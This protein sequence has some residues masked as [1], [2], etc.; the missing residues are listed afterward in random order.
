[1]DE[2]TDCLLLI[3]LEKVVLVPSDVDRVQLL[4]VS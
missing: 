3:Y 2:G 1:M 4:A